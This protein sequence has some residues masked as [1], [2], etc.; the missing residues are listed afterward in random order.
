M[1]VTSFLLITEDTLLIVTAGTNIVS[2]TLGSSFLS[3]L[4]NFRSFINFLVFTGATVVIL[5][6]FKVIL[7]SHLPKLHRDCI[8]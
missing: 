3:K 2:V 4:G 6:Q 8:F 1:N 5:N 7:M